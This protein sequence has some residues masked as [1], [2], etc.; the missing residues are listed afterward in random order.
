MRFEDEPTVRL[1]VNGLE[2]SVRVEPRVTLVDALRD[3]LGLTGTKKGCDRGECG[4]CTVHIEGRRVLAC[5]TLA[6]MVDGAQITTIEG[7]ADDGRRH[8]VQEVF[9]GADAFQCGFCT[10]GQVMSA[11]ACIGE[12]H[13]GSAAEIKE[14]MSGNL[15]RC[16]AYPQ[17]VAAV[18]TAA[19]AAA[20]MRNFGYAKAP[21]MAA[22]MDALATPGT[23]VI[24]GGT[25][26]VNW[27][28]EGITTPDRIV[29]IT[30]LPLAG[31]EAGAAGLR[32]GAL[33]PMAEIG[34]HP[35]V[36]RDYPV[37]AEALLASASP[38]LRAMATIGGNL[39]QRT[40]CPY[41][42]AETL[43]GCNQRVAGS[44]CSALDGDTR[45]A[46]IFGWSPQCVATHPSDLAVALS[47]LDATVEV[48]GGPGTRTV[49]MDQFYRQPG[50]DS[51]LSAVD[52][53]ELVVAVTVPGTPP[54]AR[55][56]YLKV[57]ERVSYEFAVVSAAAVVEL[58]GPL[59]TG[60]RLALGGVAHRPWRLTDAEA[61]LLGVDIGDLNSL[62]AAVARGFTDARP[63]PGNGFKVEL[64]QRAAVRALRVAAGAP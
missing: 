34:A 18:Q 57:R 12:G 35:Q 33:A 39:L 27:L 17:I 31:V 8:P 19:A 59:L 21:D 61:A 23:E 36:A 43:L 10:P 9:L 15:C 41:F 16:A 46:A 40:R 54:A 22:A 63:L 64:A 44:G 4:A 7:L 52:P 45:A 25:E 58:D 24:A 62:W 13:A 2:H 49:P 11:V 37:L 56:H 53:D 26:L 3:R 29:D 14:W 20:A 60:A 5:M 50:V 55:S 1:L 28:K 32:L 47:A 30:D 6:V 48:H 51:R 42:R 38:Q